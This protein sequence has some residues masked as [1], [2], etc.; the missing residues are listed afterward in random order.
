M[1][2]R[3][4]LGSLCLAPLVLAATLPVLPAQPTHSTHEMVM[5]APADTALSPTARAQLDAARRATAA[6]STPQAAQAAGYR[7]IFGEIP[8]QGE[9]YV[10]MD[11]VS[12]DSFDLTH[13]SVLMFAPVNGTP[14]LVGAAYAFLHPSSSPP[15]QGF[16]GAEDVWHTHDR[17]THVPGK[18][19]VMMHTWFVDAPLGPFARYNPWLPYLAAGLTPPRADLLT[20]TTS[21]DRV[22]RFGMALALVVEP[23]LIV[24]FADSRGGDSLRASVAPHRDAIVAL[25]PKLRAAQQRGD[26]AVYETLETETIA[27]GD[28]MLAAYRGAAGA[29]VR[30]QRVIDRLVGAYMGRELEM[31]HEMG[32]A[33]SR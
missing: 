12:K 16:D 24:Q 22:Y 19:I 33:P 27:E 8:L 23:P 29:N 15:P 21:A 28:A 11:L 6:L 31:Q 30:I 4:H 14:T 13:P 3:M 26:G 32:H 20:D 18:H 17:L 1:T 25:L 10:R 7:P 2:V 9:H 5:D